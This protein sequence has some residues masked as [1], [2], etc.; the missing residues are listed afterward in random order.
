M[1]AQSY[2]RY[3]VC[4]LQLR[5]STAFPEL[6]EDECAG[7]DVPADIEFEIC[8]DLA[9]EAGAPIVMRREEEDGAPWLTCTST[10]RGY[11]LRFSG[12][13]DFL[14]DRAGHR[15][16]GAAHPGTPP[17]TMRHLFLDQ[18]IPRMLNL[19]GVEALHASAIH[20]EGGA[21]AF[22][23]GSGQGKSTLAA[24]F[25]RAGVP[26]LCDDCLLVAGDSG[27]VRVAPAYPGFRLW[28]DSREA[29]FG[30]SH[31]TLPVSHSSSKRR[32]LAPAP[33]C[34]PPDRRFLLRG[35]YALHRDEEG[36]PLQAPAIEAL[37]LREAFMALTGCAFRLDLKD[38]AA[39]LRQMHLME[40]VAR[41]VPVS[42][43]RLPDD[44]GRLDSA[45][46]RILRDMEGR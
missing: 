10:E 45:C 18:V 2:N 31:P 20:F 30:D 46:D 13:A 16:A 19:R 7:H 28:D 23:G 8:R 6:A 37:S 42:R 12:L 4:G 32:I 9:P 36:S 33:D 1:Q 39:I 41:E 22:I 21:Y 14:V 24:A 43:L 40:Q 3:R 25:H 26:V 35:V 5:S 38:Q 34:A 17:E 11:Q 44:L 29:L 27:Q 15:V